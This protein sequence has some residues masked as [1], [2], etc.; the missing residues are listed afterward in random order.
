MSPTPDYDLLAVEFLRCQ[1]EGRHLRA[2][3]R[4]VGEYRHNAPDLGRRRARKA[5]LSA[6]ANVAGRLVE[7]LAKIDDRT[8]V[9]AL[10]RG[11][12]QSPVSRVARSGDY[13]DP[14]LHVFP[15]LAGHL[16]QFKGTL[17]VLQRGLVALAAETEVPVKGGQPVRH[18]ALQMGIE[19]IA[20]MWTKHR[21]RQPTE[22][23]NSGGF[24]RF[25][26]MM[27]TSA[28]VCFPEATVKGAV[29]EFVRRQK[30][31]A[32]T[33]DPGDSSASN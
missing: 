25:A 8:Q 24:A 10:Q 15:V 12:G 22:S 6:A 4:S 28:P 9:E 29:A 32:P 3:A 2:L 5:D 1:D 11:T 16:M 30:A 27:F 26:I 21:G 17:E 31:C 18:D 13:P 33:Q 14:T 7:A 20:A 19:G 23:Y